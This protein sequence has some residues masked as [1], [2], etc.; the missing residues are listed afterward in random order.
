MPSASPPLIDPL[1][2]G[3]LRLFCPAKIN[4][5]LSV[6]SPRTDGLHPIASWMVPIA[7]GDTLVLRR[8]DGD[9]SGAVRIRFAEDAPRPGAVDWPIE[10]D[11]A[12]RAWRAAEAEVG[13]ALPIDAEV[14]KRVPAGAGLGGGSADAAAMLDGLDRLFS[15]NLGE[16]RL[17]ALAGE[18]GADVVFQFIARRRPGGAVVTGTGETIDMLPPAEPCPLLLLL[19]GFGCPTGAVYAAFDRA[20]SGATHPP[21]VGRVRALAQQPLQADSK[22]FND[23]ADPACLVRPELRRVIDSAAQLGQHPHVTG[24]GAAAFILMEPDGAAALQQNRRRIE[25]AAGCVVIVTQTQASSGP[26]DIPA[27]GNAG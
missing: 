12:V 7:F 2:G 9:G 11:L 10:R 22:L 20:L 14:I 16:D 25:Q 15:L 1:A 18:L 5:A 3:G 19:P 8:A 4:L 23:L 21:D 24:S 6:G 27:G 26:E 17:Q 13:R